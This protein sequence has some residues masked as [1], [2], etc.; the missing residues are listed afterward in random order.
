MDLATRRAQSRLAFARRMRDHLRDGTS[1]L[2]SAPMR[3][4]VEVYTDPA[5]HAAERKLLRETPVVVCLSADLR[6][7]GQYRTFDDTGVPVVVVR[8]RDRRLRAFLNIC[9]HRGARLVREPAGKANL[10][11]CWFHGWSFDTA[12]RLVA[13]P[14]VERFGDAI[15]ERDHLIEV[16]AGERCGLV[17]VQAT[18]GSSMDLDAH[19][20]DFASELD[21]LELDKA[22]RVKDGTLP[23]AA[24]WK[25]AL[26][27]YGEG[28]HFAALHKATLSPYFRNDITV[29][30]RFGPHHRVGF[31]SRAMERWLDLPEAD[32]GAEDGGGGIHYIFP[33]TILFVGSVRPGKSFYTTFRHFPGEAVGETLTHKT[34][35]APSGGANDAAVRAEV[36]AGFDATANVVMTEDYVVA[37]EGWRNLA[38]LPAGST[39]VYGRQELALH[40]VHHAIAAAIGTP[41]PE[42]VPSPMREAA[43]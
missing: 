12:G 23:V 39:V 43:E 38:Y 18:P 6:E 41:L 20:G 29:Y 26:D 3:N 33:N 19:L 17:F 4:A 24:N 27:T 34:T 21:L 15:P 36:E 30:D 31:A 10:L 11:T 22:E 14:E 2:A 35:Y 42:T 28:Y 1:D 37:A 13:V 16:P 8:G 40:N 5:R 25:Y 9:T 7:P 32:W